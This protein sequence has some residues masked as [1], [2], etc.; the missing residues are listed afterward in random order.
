MSEILRESP[1]IYGPE[2]AGPMPKNYEVMAQKWKDTN[3][4]SQI[5]AS[6]TKIEDLKE[7][8]LKHFKNAPYMWKP[9]QGG[10]WGGMLM[11]DD[12]PYIHLV[13][14]TT[15]VVEFLLNLKSDKGFPKEKITLREIHT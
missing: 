14:A 2:D 5:A 8:H 6:F 3:K 7:I 4:P 10:I 15:P 13:L 11:D 1:K 9:L 12:I